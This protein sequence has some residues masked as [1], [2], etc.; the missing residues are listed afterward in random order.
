MSS[1]T[2]P[3]RGMPVDRNR[4]EAMI[5]KLVAVQMDLKPLCENSGSELQ[6]SK[7]RTIAEACGVLQSAIDDLKKVIL[8]LEDLPGMTE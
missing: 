8:E 3:E 7:G 1:Q 6:G 4:L 5:D 2:P